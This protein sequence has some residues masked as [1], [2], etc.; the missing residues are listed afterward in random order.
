LIDFGLSKRYID[1]NGKHITRTDKRPFRGTLRYCS[2]NM[3]LGVENSRRDDLESLAYVLIYLAKG[4]LPWQNIKLEA[5]QK[6]E[7]I[8][9]IKLNTSTSLLC[10]G[11]PKE[12]AEF[13]RLVKNLEFTET[14]AYDTYCQLLASCINIP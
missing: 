5:N 14:P 1:D 10:E 2:A 8:A 3:H 11:L 6:M 7:K 4:K 9:K 12:Y 13:L